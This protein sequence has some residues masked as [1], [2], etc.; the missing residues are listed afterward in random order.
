MRMNQ[1]TPPADSG[2]LTV[3]HLSD[4]H[5]TSLNGVHWRQLLNKRLLGYLSWRKKRRAEHRPE[6]LEALLQD[7]HETCPQHIAITGDLTQVGLA[8][9]FRQAR[10]WLDRV[11][12]GTRVT[13]VPGNHEAYVATDWADT[14]AQWEPFLC[15]DP[16]YQSA[17]PAGEGM[18]PSLRVRNGVA[19]IGLSS[20]VPT[21]PFLA[22]G[23]LGTDQRERL[24][25]LLRRTGA[26]GL[27]RLV[28]IHHPPRVED[29]KWRKRLR[30]GRA[31]CAILADAGAE[32][33]LH[34]HGHYF[35]ASH[36]NS[37]RGKIPVFGIPS[38][39]AR[40]HKP[41]RTAQYRL[42]RVRRCAENWGVQV[43]VRQ[44]RADL[45]CF[46]AHGQHHFSLPAIPSTS[47]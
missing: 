27:F 28:L 18:F 31:L 1:Q 10:Q 5:L 42:Y 4:P 44:Y 26:Q 35:S 47:F 11:G 20:A 43:D 13:V 15:S 21:A 9:E 36:V 38:A 8:E 17:S 45:G 46:V 30:D 41:G 34:G 6:I 2:G 37:A 12:E 14:Y 3:A 16:D 24:A 25:T 33:V 29:E 40:G 32:L 7:L 39:S 22:S 23:R 19:F